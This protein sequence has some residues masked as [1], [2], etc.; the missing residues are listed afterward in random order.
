MALYEVS[1]GPMANYLIEVMAM[2]LQL[3]DTN[4]LQ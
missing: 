2:T 3:I 1:H 4:T